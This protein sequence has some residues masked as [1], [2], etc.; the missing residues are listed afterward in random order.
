MQE[1][2]LGASFSQAHVAC[3]RFLAWLAKR[4]WKHPSRFS[5]DF[6]WGYISLH[7]CMR[8]RKL[9]APCDGPH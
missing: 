9:V 2:L 4:H 5:I 6:C 7:V 1:I 3:M 8:D